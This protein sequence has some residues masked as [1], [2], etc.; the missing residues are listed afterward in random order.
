[1]KKMLL[2]LAAVA[3][4]T[5]WSL[6]TAAA[7]QSVQ[8]TNGPSVQVNGNSAMLTWSTNVGSSAIVHYGTD[9]N[10][11]SQTAES[12]WS[13]GQHTVTL[14]NLQ[15][16][17]TYYFQVESAQGQ[18]TGTGTMSRIEQFQVPNTNAYN[19]GYGYNNSGYSS[20]NG[21]YNSSQGQYQNNGQVQI[22]QG[23]VVEALSGNSATIAWDTSAPSN[24]VLMYGT[25]PSSL[26]Q[27]AEAPWG[28]NPHR[29]TI[30]NLQP[31]TTYFFQVQSSQAQ[32]TGSG[33][34]SGVQQF[35]TLSQGQQQQFTRLQQ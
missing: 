23:P 14:N 7:Q 10:N 24:T 12:P 16:G 22:T 6:G 19:N 31:N 32:G 17:S 35:R 18:G 20:N 33:T 34:M 3:A 30:N 28:Q 25:N 8:I 2:S 9:P 21:Y 13:N 26:N 29:V 27:T 1:M 15:P 5:M 4:F 11:L